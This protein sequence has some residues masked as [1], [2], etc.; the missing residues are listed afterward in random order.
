M[1]ALRRTRDLLLEK[2]SDI[3]RV[4]LRLLEKE[5]L[6]REDMIELVGKRP[7]VEK[8]TYEEMVSGTGGLDENVEL[9]KGLEN[10]NKE[11]EKKKKDEEKKKNDE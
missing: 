2:R 6:N 7:F 4:A 3:E 10:W 11:S 8:N 5:I 1:N 9:P